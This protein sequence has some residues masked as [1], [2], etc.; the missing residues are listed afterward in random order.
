MYSK[1]LSAF[2]LETSSVI[3]PVGSGLI[4]RTYKVTSSQGDFVLQQLH[5]VISDAAVLDMATVGLFLRSQGMCVPA[6]LQTSHSDYIFRDADGKRW[7]MY[8]WMD[9]EVYDTVISPEMI[10][11]AATLVGRMHRLL[12]KTSYKPVGSILHFHETEYI[13]HELADVVSDLPEEVRA[14]AENILKELPSLLIKDEYGAP[15]VIHG[16]LKISNILFDANGSAIGILDFDTLLFHHRGID[17]GDAFR[18]WCNP[19]KEDEQN[20]CLNKSIFQSAVRGYASGFGEEMSDVLCR[21][22][23]KQ[24]ALELACRFLIDVVRD[25][26]FGFDTEKYATRREHNLARARG[27]YTFAESIRI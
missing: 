11:N 2:G 25:S 22:A 17:L 21:R 4:H 16:D 19:H 6:L 23:T 12:Q 13:L 1:I 20:S 24:L 26:Y 18:S 8:P 3:K 5:D 15:Q 27:Q 9:G 14:M 7:R 10:E